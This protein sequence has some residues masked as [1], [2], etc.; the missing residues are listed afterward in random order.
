MAQGLNA[1]DRF[2]LQTALTNAGLSYAGAAQLAN[3]Q[4]VTDPADRETLALVIALLL[5]LS[6]Q[7]GGGIKAKSSKIKVAFE[8]G[9]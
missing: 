8:V 5:S 7:S 9:P 4:I 2:R 6:Q 3:E 1:A